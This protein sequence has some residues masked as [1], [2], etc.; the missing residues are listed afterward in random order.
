L[1]LSPTSQSF[2][3]LSRTREHAASDHVGFLRIMVI[4]EAYGGDFIR[5]IDKTFQIS[6]HTVQKILR[7]NDL[8]KFP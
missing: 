6:I 5:K 3:A 4:I 1:L 7:G 8:L 2:P